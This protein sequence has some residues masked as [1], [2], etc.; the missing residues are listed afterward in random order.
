LK[1]ARVAVVTKEARISLYV[2]LVLERSAFMS[3]MLL[4]LLITA[5]KWL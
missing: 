1:L 4:P 5:L 2:T 3:M